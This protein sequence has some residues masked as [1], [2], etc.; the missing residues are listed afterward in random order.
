MSWKTID[1]APMNGEMVVLIEEGCR[2][3]FGYFGIDENFPEEDPQ[4][5]D[6]SYDDFSIGYSAC[7]ME[8]THWMALPKLPA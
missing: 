7:P 4:W 1:T 8:P 5:F 2:P 3:R 6:D